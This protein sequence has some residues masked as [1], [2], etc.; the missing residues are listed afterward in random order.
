[1]PTTLVG[2]HQLHGWWKTLTAV[3]LVGSSCVGPS[4]GCVLASD[5][6]VMASISLCPPDQFLCCS[7]PSSSPCSFT[8]IMNVSKLGGGGPHF[9]YMARVFSDVLFVCGGLPSDI[10]SAI[11]WSW[12]R[13]IMPATIF[14]PRFLAPR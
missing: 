10:T 8:V 13:S 3:H 14:G 1:M 11:P 2:W 5:R 12:K 9:C 7:L 6:A 4:L